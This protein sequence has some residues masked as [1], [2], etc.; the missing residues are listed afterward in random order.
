MRQPVETVMAVLTAS[1]KGASIN[2]A[3]KASEIHQDCAADRGGTPR[4]AGNA[5]LRW[6]ADSSEPTINQWDFPF[7]LTIGQTAVW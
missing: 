7:G 2:A 4:S 1:R 5:G 6:S 3:A